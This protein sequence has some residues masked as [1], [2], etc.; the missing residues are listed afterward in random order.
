MGVHWRQ[1]RKKCAIHVCCFSISINCHFCDLDVFL[2]DLHVLK[3]LHSHKSYN[4]TGEM[5]LLSQSHHNKNSA[6]STRTGRMGFIVCWLMLQTLTN[7]LIGTI[8]SECPFPS[9][10]S[11]ILLPLNLLGSTLVPHFSHGLCV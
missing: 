5:R 4:I 2:C 10:F 9:C 11:L 1:R 7:S 8:L 6:Q 3:N